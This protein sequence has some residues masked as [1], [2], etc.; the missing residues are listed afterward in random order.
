MNELSI[1]DIKLS[2]Y[3]YELP[4]ERIAKFPLS[5]RDQSKLQVYN[6]GEI[7]HT[8]FYQ[9]ADYLPE[10]SLLVF[11]NTKVIP[12]RIHFQK[13]TG[14]T[15]QIFLLHPIAPTAVINL[16]MEVSDSCIW[17]CMIGNKKRLKKNDILLRTLQV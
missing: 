16:A 13:P 15:I 5:E 7:T 8:Q 14:A 4:D 17:E 3:T 11:N 2:D 12:A 6:Q 1:T 9:I 10:G